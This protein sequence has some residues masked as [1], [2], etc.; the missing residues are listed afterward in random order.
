MTT[1]NTAPKGKS[2]FVRAEFVNADYLV[3][4]ELHSRIVFTDT[5]LSSVKSRVETVKFAVKFTTL[6]VKTLVGTDNSGLFIEDNEATLMALIAHKVKAPL[7]AKQKQFISPLLRELTK[8]NAS[9]GEG[10]ENVTITAKQW[11]GIMA[12]VTGFE[13]SE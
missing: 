1:E 9:V 8:I 2:E 4:N 12:N 5:E 13:A 7:E 6:V 11:A 10:D 3:F